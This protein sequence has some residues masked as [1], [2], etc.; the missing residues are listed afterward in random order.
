MGGEIKKATAPNI[1]EAAA[2]S[3]FMLFGVVS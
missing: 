2:R 1:R 3:F